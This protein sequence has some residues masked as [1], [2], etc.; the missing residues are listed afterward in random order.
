MERT[1]VTAYIRQAIAMLLIYIFCM[2]L[3]VSFNPT[4][5]KM[6]CDENY[7]CTVQI[8][9]IWNIRR[10]GTFTVNKDAKM[11]FYYNGY[12]LRSGFLNIYGGE[13]NTDPFGTSDFYDRNF[14][15]FYQKNK[16]T[17]TEITRFDNYIKNPEMK[18]TLDKTYHRMNFHIWSIIIT[19]IFIAFMLTERPLSNFFRILNS[20]SFRRL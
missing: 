10:K 5:G 11:Q 17:K 2:V 6:T 7:L 19:L 18:Y 13:L 14:S 3:I 4:S 9:Y 15:S 1:N 16:T 8:Q 20:I 12:S